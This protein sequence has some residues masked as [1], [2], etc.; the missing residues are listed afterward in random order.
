MDYPLKA[1]TGRVITKETTGI[2]IFK[3]NPLTITLDMPTD[4]TIT[5]KATLMGKKSTLMIL[6]TAPLHMLNQTIV[7]MKGMGTIQKH[8]QDCQ[9][10]HRTK[11]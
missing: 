8:L 6:M 1:T 10:K 4:S 9:N 3:V 5:T 11:K 7:K 2:Q